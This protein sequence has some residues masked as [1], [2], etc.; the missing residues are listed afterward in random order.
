MQVLNGGAIPQGWNDT[1]VVLIPKVKDPHSLKDLRPINLCNVLYKI[2]SKVLAG[3]LKSILDGIISPN[4]S[5]FV[6]GRLIKDNILVAY[7]M[8]H[9]LLKNKR[10]GN[11]GYLALKLDMSKAYDRVE[12]DFIEA[13]LVKLG[14]NWIFTDL[15]MKCVR[16]VK[17][18]IKVNKEFTTETIPERGL[19]QGDP[20]SPYLFLICA[21]GLSALL[22]QAETNELIQGI[23][24]CRSAPSVTHLLFAD[25]SLILMKADAMNVQKLLRYP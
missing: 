19:W 2:I 17:Y 10:G 12:W 23:K 9:F 21:E 8:T 4:Q 5:A 7:E 3:R 16:S 22:H 24:V 15:L 14:F 13:M 1:T 18:K 11:A 6:L 25:D 20:L